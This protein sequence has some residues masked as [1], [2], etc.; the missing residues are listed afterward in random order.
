M[1]HVVCRSQAWQPVDNLWHNVLYKQ[2][3][4]IGHPSSVLDRCLQQLWLRVVSIV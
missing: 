1:G 4:H 3:D 2:T